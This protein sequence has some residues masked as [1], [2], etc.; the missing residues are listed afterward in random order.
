MSPKLLL[1]LLTLV[2]V[3]S[4]SMLHPF[5]PQ[6]FAEV[7]GVHEPREVGLYI[8]SSCLAVLLAFPLW[9]LLAQ[10][11]DL[12]ALLL[13]TQVAAGVLSLVCATLSSLPWFWGVSLGML[14]F[15]ASYLLIYPRVLAYESKEEHVGTISLLAFVVYFGHIVA[16]LVSGALFA[17]VTPRSLFVLMAGGDALQLALC[18][19]WLRSTR[20]V[21][22]AP[23]DEESTQ[24]ARAVPR[25]FFARLG[26]VMFL[27]YFSAYLTEPFFSTYWERLSGVPHRALTGAVFAIPGL[28][29]L[30][31]LALNTRGRGP[32]SPYAGIVSAALVTAL[33]MGLQSVE[34][35]PLVL[36]GRFVYGWGLFQT[37]VRLDALLFQFSE[38]DSYAF[39]FS[40]VYLFQGLGGLFSS[41]CAG[42]LAEQAGPRTTFLLAGLGFVA[43][44]ALYG[45]VFRGALWAGAAPDSP[46]PSLADEGAMS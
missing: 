40:K 23:A 1:A 24:K 32:M 41:L 30:L 34:L 43:S 9:A 4:D 13:A 14:A 37:I 21:E 42:T 15:K 17:W 31:G 29:A 12:R 10:R 3:V 35:S 46:S 7:F 18:I 38:P 26:V 6:Y 16:A 20:F 5:Y 8:A 27:V 25:W 19:Y 44:A 33:G 39:E 2:A 11:L 45:V 22:A 36:A 28:A